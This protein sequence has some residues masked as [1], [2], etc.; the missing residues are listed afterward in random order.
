MLKDE[1]LT[2]A[3]VAYQLG[4]STPQYF[5]NCFKDYFGIKPPEYQQR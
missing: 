3:E 2:I 1:K 5:S 4:F